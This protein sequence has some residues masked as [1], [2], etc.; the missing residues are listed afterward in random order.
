M[1]ACRLVLFGLKAGQE[2]R[3]HS[4]KPKV[5]MFLISGK[6]FFNAGERE[7]ESEE[8]TIVICEPDEAH[9][10]RALQQMIVLAAIIP[11]P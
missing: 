3:P 7:K 10:M 8:G 4:V 1:P 6:G 9:G 5:I 11:S 2:V